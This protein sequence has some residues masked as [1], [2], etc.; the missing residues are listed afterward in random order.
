[1]ADWDNCYKFTSL[2]EERNDWQPTISYFI[3][4]VIIKKQNERDWWD[5]CLLNWTRTEKFS[6]SINSTYFHTASDNCFSN[7]IH[8]VDW[9]R[10]YL[11]MIPLLTE[12]ENVI[13]HKHTVSTA[14]LPIITY[15]E[16]NILSLNVFK[17]CIYRKNIEVLCTLGPR[18]SQH[19][20]NHQGKL[21]EGYWI[22][23]KNR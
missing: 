6:V 10:W 17:F 14:V 16:N 4:H 19:R 8:P 5:V 20:C 12:E 1:M 22:S 11:T 23:T 9:V 7:S 18:I 15:Y 2:E 3:F 21:R 13:L